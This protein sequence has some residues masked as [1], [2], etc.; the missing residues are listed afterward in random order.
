VWNGEKLELCTKKRITEYILGRIDSV[1]YEF[2]EF[3]DPIQHRHLLKAVGRFAEEMGRYLDMWQLQDA[4]EEKGEQTAPVIVFSG[5]VK[6]NHRTNRKEYLDAM[7]NAIIGRYEESKEQI[8]RH[9]RA[10][11]NA[12]KSQAMDEFLQYVHEHGIEEFAHASD[13]FEAYLAYGKGPLKFEDHQ[14]LVVPLTTTMCSQQLLLQTA[15]ASAK[16]SRCLTSSTGIAT[17]TVWTG[18]V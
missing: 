10:R 6:Q 15:M 18:R 17:S 8:E 4:L 2:I 13:M 14:K 11:E 16:C 7:F 12:L 1:L 9:M 3:L 5:K